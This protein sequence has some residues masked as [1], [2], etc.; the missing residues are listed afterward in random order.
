VPPPVITATS[1][2][3][4]ERLFAATGTEDILSKFRGSSNWVVDFRWEW[5]HT[6]GYCYSKDLI[7]DDKV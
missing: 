5:C 1:P 7:V 3:T 4:W 2:G 6:R